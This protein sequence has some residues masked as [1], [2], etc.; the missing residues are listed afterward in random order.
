MNLNRRFSQF[1]LPVLLFVWVVLY[2]GYLGWKPGFAYNA[3]RY[4]EIFL[5]G[6]LLCTGAILPVRFRLGGF[7]ACLCLALLFIMLLVVWYADNHWLAIREGLQYVALFAAI[8]VVAKTRQHAGVADFDRAAYIGLTLFSFGCALIVLEGLLLSISINMVDSRIVFGAFVNVRVFA[9]LQFLTLFLLP[10]VWL[11]MNSPGWRFFIGLTAM[12][13]WGLLLLTGTRSALVVL[14]F[15]L[16][17]LGLTGGRSTLSWFRVLVTQFAGGILVFL[18]L[19]GSV[20]W[21]LGT[22]LWGQGSMSFARSSSS[23][24][25]DLW[26]DAWNHFLQ[27][28]WLGNGP[29]AFACFT[30]ELV[31][32]PHNLIFQ[33]L[34]EWGV[35]IT[36]LS[37]TL[38]SLMFVALVRHL[39]AGNQAS[40]LEFSLLATLVATVAACMMEG[41][42]IGPLQQ[43]LV[44]WVFGWALHVFAQEKFVPLTGKAP[45]GYQRIYVIGIALFLA[46]VLWGVK[47][48]LVLQKKLLVSPDGVVNLSYAPRFWADGHDHCLEW[49]E[50]YQNR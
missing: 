4:F 1:L 13:S 28:P 15:A 19:R 46:I 23:G 34:S 44:V 35:F 8:L 42:I 16:L 50:R 5:L 43:M 26:A 24:R 33:L 7:W 14:P 30:S 32:T 10:A 20:A 6:C 12:L 9:E 47:A 31:A 25:L 45:C 22:S 37:L 38:A 36:L 3:Q 27:H 41:M 17:V 48:D 21:Y 29:G 2:F 39:R 18:L 11:Q 40:P 49:H